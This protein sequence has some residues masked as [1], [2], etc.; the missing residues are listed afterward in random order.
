[1]YKCVNTFY[2]ITDSLILLYM[3]FCMIIHL[4]LVL[5]CILFISE[6]N[7]AELYC[8]N[9]GPKLWNSLPKCLKEI[10][11]KFKIKLKKIY[12]VSVYLNI[13]EMLIM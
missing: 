6:Q 4:V 12:F 5:I 8:P 9:P 7:V 13:A 10:P 11:I 1:M 2:N 3:I